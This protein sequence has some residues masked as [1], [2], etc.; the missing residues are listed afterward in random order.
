MNDEKTVLT[1]L[2]NVVVDLSH[3]NQTVD[4]KKAKQDGIL[5][6]IHKATEGTNYTDPT[7]QE[8]RKLAM[9]AGLMWGAYH[10]GSGGD[11][12]AQAEYFLKA[13]DPGPGGTVFSKRVPLAAGG[14]IVQPKNICK[15][16]VVRFFHFFFHPNVQP[17]VY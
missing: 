17:L 11:G 14:K 13:V 8:R 7:Y 5:G 10:F 12:N 4:L 6:V 9:E 15:T 2:L 16:K 1:D 3:H